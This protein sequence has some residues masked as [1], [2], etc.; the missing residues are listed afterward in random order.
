[1]YEL[2]AFHP[3]FMAKDFPA[4]MKRVTAGYYDPVP[5]KYSKKLSMLIRRC[6]TVDFKKRPSASDLL[7]MDIFMMMMNT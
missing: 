6:L 7:D 5:S 2:T 3:P 4:L 1:M